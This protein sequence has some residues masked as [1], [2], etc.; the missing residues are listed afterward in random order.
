MEIPAYYY[1]DAKYVPNNINYVVSMA[2]HRVP[3][4]QIDNIQ[5]TFL[6]GKVEESSFEDICEKTDKNLILNLMKV[7]GRQGL[8]SQEQIVLDGVHNAIL[9]FSKSGKHMA[10]FFKSDNLLNVYDSSDIFKC[11]E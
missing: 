11:F 6:D 3:K 4:T 9:E 8:I 2:F 1:Y 5:T 7:N 10:I